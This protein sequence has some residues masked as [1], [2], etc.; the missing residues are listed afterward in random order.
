LTIRRLQLKTDIVNNIE[1]YEN[2]EGYDNMDV[3]KVSK[4]NLCPLSVKNDL[5]RRLSN[6]NSVNEIDKKSA[7]YIRNY[8]IK[9]S[10]NSAYNGEENTTE[11]I[12]YVLSRGCRFLDFEIYKDPTPGSNEPIIS[13]STSSGFAPI[14]QTKHLTLSETFMFI[15]IHGFNTVSPNHSDPLFIQLRPRDPNPSDKTRTD[16]KRI[17]S[18][19]KTAISGISPLYSGTVGNNNPIVSTTRINELL[20]KIIIVM[21][22][23]LYPDYGTLFPDL[24]NYVNMENSHTNGNT[25]TILYG[26]LPRQKWLKLS[27]DKYSC[28]LKTL[29]GILF[30]DKTGT[31]YSTNVNTDILY[32]KYSCQIIPMMYWNNGS[33]LYNHEMMFNYCGGGIVPLSSIYK[34]MK[35]NQKRKWNCH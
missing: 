23:T 30:T 14:S 5:G 28:D 8:A 31:T 32:E 16:L 21:D 20:G 27:K 7:L 33:D 11:M 9:S 26:D 3:N 29:R 24:K 34:K 2:I 1:E 22:T 12:D 19:I 13:V 25:D 18:A 4:N 10:M 6:I 35:A 15:N 17:L